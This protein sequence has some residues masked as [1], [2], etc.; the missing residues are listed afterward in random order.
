MSQHVTLAEPRI[1]A[2]AG[3][4][5]PHH[6]SSDRVIV[7]AMASSQS[8]EAER[9]ARLKELGRGSRLSFRNIAESRLRQD[10]KEEAMEICDPQ[11]KAFAECSQE[12]GL[13]VVFSCHHLFKKVQECLN[14]H[15]GEEA[16]QKYKAEHLDELEDRATGRKPM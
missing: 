15:N 2:V 14:T 1:I 10:L 11:I 16:W 12:K 3:S 13:M 8:D 9:R 6:F 7:C 5:P 4:L